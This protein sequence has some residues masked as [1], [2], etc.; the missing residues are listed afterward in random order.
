MLDGYAGG[1]GERDAAFGFDDDG[2]DD[3]DDD[4]D[5]GRDDDE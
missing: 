2:N 3:D 4:D 1:V 5:S